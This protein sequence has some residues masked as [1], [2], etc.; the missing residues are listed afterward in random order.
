MDMDIDEPCDY[1]FLY[2]E[3][4]QEVK[5]VI[6]EMEALKTELAKARE[7]IAELYDDPLGWSIPE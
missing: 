4:M 6:A 7:T 1:A 3:K 2:Y 5:K